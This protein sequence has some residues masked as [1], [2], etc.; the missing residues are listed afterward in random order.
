MATSD[1][2]PI[3]PSG[4]SESILSRC[5]GAASQYPT[6]GSAPFLDGGGLDCDPSQVPPGP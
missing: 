5:P 6:D 3:R 4:I 1:V 2:S